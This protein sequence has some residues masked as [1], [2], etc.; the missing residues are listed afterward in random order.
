MNSRYAI[1]LGWKHRSSLQRIDLFLT[2]FVLANIACLDFDN[3]RWM[4]RWL[5]SNKL[6]FKVHHPHY[7]KVWRNTQFWVSQLKDKT[8]RCI[9]ITVSLP[10]NIHLTKCQ[11]IFVV[12]QI[13]KYLPHNFDCYQTKSEVNQK[14]YGL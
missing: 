11:A 4:V 12:F 2:V 10:T 14:S 6:I 1:L 13:R 8:R 7:Y 9:N 3:L 5:E